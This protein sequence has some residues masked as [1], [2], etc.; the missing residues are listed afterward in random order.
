MIHLINIFHIVLFA[1]RINSNK[2]GKGK[3]KG[4]RS[5]L[6]HNHDEIISS[7]VI[8]SDFSKHD[9][10]QTP[11]F[12]AESK[13]VELT[14]HVES[15]PLIHLITTY[16]SYLILI[17]TGHIRDFVLRWI[18]PTDFKHLAPQD[19]L[20]PINSGFDTFYHRNLYFRIRDVFNRPVTGVPGRTINII[21]RT[22]DDYN[23]TFTYG[24]TREVL[25]L[26]SY[27]YLGFGENDGPCTDAVEMTVKKYGIS[28]G[29][30]RLEA[31]TLDLHHETEQLV[32]RF[33]GQESAIICS[34][35]F[36]TNSTMI[37]ALIGKGG[38]IISDELNHSSL[39][40]GARISGAV[41]RVF[42][43]KYASCLI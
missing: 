42:K 41:I 24:K 34:M 33:L 18:K 31:G 20:A 38:L 25:N 3:G 27:N 13:P 15:V 6:P 37:P 19:G 35:G 2:M 5:S 21:T 17:L 43:H 26:S 39:I 9:I 40:F 7:S 4:Q 23:H 32:A 1:K 14:E 11:L 29:S 16:I 10:L 28:S 12:K 30:S 22:S 36:A 8:S